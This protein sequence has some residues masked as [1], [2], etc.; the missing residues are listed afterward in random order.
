MKIVLIAGL[1]MF[2]GVASAQVLKCIDNSGKVVGYASECP[3]GSRSEKMAIQKG[4]A[5]V[6]AA[7]PAQK[8]LADRDADFRK[9]Q[10]ERQESEKK[11]AEQATNTAQRKRACEESQAH[12]RSVQK[13]ERISRLDPKTGERVFVE[14]KDYPAEVAKAKTAVDTN[15][16]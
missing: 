14:D 4:P 13:G 16:K 8:S 11:T 9:R 15:C 5:S 1:M 12:Y 7:E 10:V 2:S 3:P 6:P